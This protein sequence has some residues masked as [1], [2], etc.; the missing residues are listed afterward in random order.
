MYFNERET[1]GHVEEQLQVLNEITLEKRKITKLE[2]HHGW[3]LRTSGQKDKWR[4]SEFSVKFTPC[5]SYDL[6]QE[7]EI[8]KC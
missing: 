7:K 4:G 8:H 2:P 3:N 6:S 1:I 5:V